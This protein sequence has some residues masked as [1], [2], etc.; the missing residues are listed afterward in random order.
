MRVILIFWGCFVAIFI[1]AQDNRD[2]RF[3]NNA[4]SVI[5]TENYVDQ[6]YVVIA[7]NGDWVCVQTTGPGKES[8]AGQHIAATISSDKG[9][10]W[11]SLINIEPSR[12]I[13]SS[14][15]IPYVTSYGRIYVFYSFNGDNIN[16]KPN[17][18]PL[19]VNTIQGWF[20]FKYSDD[21]GRT[22]S[23]KRYRLPM[24]KTTVDYINPWNGELQLFWSIDSP[25]SVDSSIYFAFT[26]LAI[27]AHDMGEGWF[28]KSDNIN[29]ERD[30]EKLNWELLPD[31]NIGV[32]ETSLGK[33]QEE[34][35]MVSLDNDDLYC[36][37]RTTEG[38]PGESYSRDGGHSWS[39]PEFARDKNGR[40]IK[41]PRACPKL[42][43]CENGNY[44][45]WY[46]NN[47]RRG[48]IGFRNPA[49]I[50][51]GIGKNGRIEWG[52][53]EIL[54]YGDGGVGPLNKGLHR[55]SYPSL[56]EENGNYWVTH[57]QKD[58]ILSE[59]IPPDYCKA[60]VHAIDP[61]LLNGLWRQGKDKTITR[62]GLILEKGRISQKQS[63]SFSDL[64]GLAVGSFSIEMLL[65]VN[66]LIP[67]Q[68]LLDNRDSK[69][70]GVS[71]SVSL[72][73]T[74]E[75]S[76]K[77][78]QVSSS[79]YTD[80]GI[81]QPG[82]HH[83]VFVVDGAANIIT[84]IV[85]GILCDGG[86]YRHTGWY[87][88]DSE[89]NNVK[90]SKN[91]IVLPNFNGEV[92]EMRIYNRHLTTSEAISN[93]YGVME[94]M[95][96]SIIKILKKRNSIN[97]VM[98]III[99]FLFTQSGC[100]SSSTET[101]LIEAESFDNKGG[102]VV[103]QQSMDQMGSPYL[104]A[105]GLGTPVE[106]AT[107]IIKVPEK[108]KY[109]VWVRTRDWVAP[110]G[111]PGFSPGKFGVLF[112]KKPLKTV[113]GTEGAEWRWQDG[114]TVRLD[115][116]KVEI[117]LHD[118]T[119]FAGRCDAIVLTKDMNFIPP[120]ESKTL[121]QFRRASLGLPEDPETAGEFDLVVV[122]GGMA[123]ITTAISAARLGCTVALIQNRPVL[124]GNNSSEVRVGL[125]GLIFQEPYPNLGKLVDEIGSIGHWT[126]WEAKRNP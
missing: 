19:S 79:W 3:I 8:T 62:K 13:P 92:T 37:F 32:S 113:F 51:G 46:H 45:L 77:D 12:E 53:P 21:H 35:N 30:P 80:P 96:Q 23:E 67:G 100:L 9:L 28:Y 15:A 17:G 124:G 73:R 89:I 55:M 34:H 93:Y 76:L 68:I 90:G 18:E 107:A 71:I 102:W 24:R 111:V 115:R 1:Q 39:V 98:S 22:W 25:I 118:M 94:K 105:H 63:I 75:I 126:L 56:I 27:H 5:P 88:F 2:W 44:L 122:G 99:A 40:V 38:Y 54:L 121:S 104:L 112:D 110:W 14:W 97:P 120:N 106:D 109:R 85:N 86:R 33:T 119:G 108:G 49:W 72:K 81:V 10:T 117:A 58:D 7:K 31:S 48:W 57:S 43:K 36:V 101:I 74:I 65:N 114:G 52:Q 83:I 50:L 125:S 4:I 66:E 91:L 16:T 59:V 42:F 82:K 26:K 61:K 84:T 123:G 64:P 6:P 103:D 70:N 41:H 87:W 69:G 95:I 29:T 47:N 20:C 78:G 116:G 60:R 11:S